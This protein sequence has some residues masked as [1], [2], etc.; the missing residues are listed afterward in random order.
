MLE[1]VREVEKIKIIERL[2]IQLQGYVY[3]GD[4]MKDGWS[5]PLPHYAFNCP[6]H[7]YVLDY[8]HGYEQRLEC[9]K[10]REEKRRETLPD[11][12]DYVVYPSK[13]AEGL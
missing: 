4:V 9:P 13:E 11:G 10:C 6:V 8:P 2:K 3:V 7:G 1:A 12:L 5:A